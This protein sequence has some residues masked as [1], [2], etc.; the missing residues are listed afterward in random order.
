M[1]ELRDE[2]RRKWREAAATPRAG[3]EWRGVALEVIGPIRF[4]A[5]VREPDDRIALLLEGPLKAAPMPPYRVMADGLSVTDQRRPEEGIFR[6]AVVLEQDGLRDVFEVLAA[7]VVEVATRASNAEASIGNAVQRLEAW[8]ACLRVRRLG[9]SMESQLGLIGE[10]IVLRML[11][12]ELGY[13]AAVHAWQGPLQG[14]HDFSRA[15]IA[16]EVKT[17]V[18]AGNW[19]HISHFAQLETHG[20]SALAIARPR[21]QET[22]NGT[23]LAETVKGIREEVLSMPATLSDFNEKM[24]RAGYL[25]IDT[26]M[27][28]SFRFKL[29]DICWFRVTPGFPCLTAAT[30]PAGIVDGT[31]TIDERSISAFRIDAL[32]VRELTLSMK[33]V[34][35]A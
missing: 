10:L 34:L 30:V 3:Y 16:I 13:P 26:A 4:V 14:V 6:I 18:G 27:Y 28:D 1:N 29:H 7:D 17:V 2:L 9:L 24:I 8:R 12:T 5:S 33:E 35:H 15:G 11:A 22:E 20:I 32:S 23:H 31:Y 25:E 19:L 21:L